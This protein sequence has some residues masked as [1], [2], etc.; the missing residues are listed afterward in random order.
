MDTTSGIVS[1]VIVPIN[2]IQTV[3]NDRVRYLIER[4]DSLEM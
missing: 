4:H 1:N 3:F 2:N